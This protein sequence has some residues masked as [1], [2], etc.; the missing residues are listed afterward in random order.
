MPDLERKTITLTEFKAAG[1]GAG[2]FSGYGST[3]G[4]VD[5]YGDIVMPGAFADTIPTFLQQ[6]FIGA[7]HD[8]DEAVA[9]PTLAREDA[10]GLYIEATFHSDSGSQDV[11][12]RMSERAAAGKSV[13]LSIG[14][15]TKQYEMIAADAAMAQGL[16]KEGDRENWMGGY[17]LLKQLELYEV[18]IVTVPA[19]RAA[20]VTGIKSPETMTFAEQQE[21]AESLV[22]G[23]KAYVDRVRRRTDA[24]EKSGRVLSQANWDALD[25]HAGQ[26][27]TLSADMRSLLEATK[28]PDDG[29]QL[30]VLHLEYE[31]TRARLHELGVA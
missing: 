6:G 21:H 26:L 2:T 10:R 16:A 31:K 15:E 19:N 30:I 11:R 27:E 3:F 24:R 23:L 7:S 18:S 22:N 8:W 12:T 9:I 25:G 4:N 28:K 29:K 14:Y 13:G 20:T 17:R 5:S 1:D